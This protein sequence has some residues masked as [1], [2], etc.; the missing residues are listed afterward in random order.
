VNVRGGIGLVLALGM[1]GALGAF[2]RI[3]VGLADPEFAQVRLSW[4]LDAEVVEDC[5]ERTSEE[6]ER[7]PAHMRSAEV[8]EGRGTPWR[9]RVE[10]DGT[11]R[12]HRIVEPR[13]AR[14]DRPVAVV[15]ELPVEV[16]THR[17]EIRFEPTDS[18]ATSEAL[19]YDDLVEL[20]SGEVALITVDPAAR[21]LVRALLEP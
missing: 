17:V 10:V 7:L 2:S 3:P 15:A 19:T 20:G 13:G 12:V 5:R 21:R 6:L 9:L 18:G 4:R 16:G 1:A 11:E 14:G 8:C